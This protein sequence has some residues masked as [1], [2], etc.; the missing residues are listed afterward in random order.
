M[1]TTTLNLLDED[2]KMA[3]ASVFEDYVAVVRRLRRECPWDREQTHES[4]RHLMIEEAYEAVDAI[5]Q[6][7][8][9]DLK[10][11][12]GDM[13]L[14][15]VFHSEIAETTTGAFVLEDVMRKSME[16]LV[17]R[18]PHVFGDAAGGDSAQILKNWELIKQEE[19]KESGEKRRSSLAGVP[20][21]LPALLRSQ[22]IQEKA[23]GVG[24][25]FL[26][27]DDAWAK[28]E[29]E[30]GEFREVAENDSDP[31]LLE[32]EFG[33]ILFSLVNYA[34]FI[35]VNAENALR[36]TADKF[37][38]QFQYI[39]ER[40]AE[41]GTSMSESSLAEM[42]ELWDEAKLQNQASR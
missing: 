42:D 8:W 34:R 24:F 37:T 40:L 2:R 20:R 25:D 38:R 7:D 36:R 10:G 27:S 23:S 28:V 22:R 32:E 39:E 1:D 33:D 5:E 26:Q 12:L 29:E 14:H 31:D 3:A 18:H 21:S 11:E 16:K 17:R 4:V 35:G 41:Q 9:E 19:R 15:V 6:G 30:L 13:L